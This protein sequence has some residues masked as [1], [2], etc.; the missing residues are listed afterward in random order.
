MAPCTMSTSELIG[1]R[2]KL[3][4]LFEMRFIRPSVSSWGALVLL[5]KEKGMFYGVVC[6]LWA[7]E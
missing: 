1:L 2:S 7:T 4:D 6:C 3:E 5:V